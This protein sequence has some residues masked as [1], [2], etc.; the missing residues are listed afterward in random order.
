MAIT[1]NGVNMSREA[2][3]QNVA[4]MVRALSMPN[5]HAEL[6][7]DISPQ[8]KLSSVKMFVDGNLEKR[9]DKVRKQLEF[10]AEA[11]DEDFGALII[12]YINDLPLEAYDTG[13]SDGERMLVWLG[14]KKQLT[15]EQD[16]YVVCQ[17][18]RHTIEDIARVNRIRHTRFTELH[19][20]AEKLSDELYTNDQLQIYLNP[21]RYWTRF[22][23]TAL[24]DEQATTPADVMFF[25]AGKET[26]T[27]ILDLE[28]QALINELADYQPCTLGQWSALSQLADHQQ[29]LELCVDLSQMG[30][31]AFG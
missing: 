29:L 27:A 22:N 26:A 8:S 31:V 10:V 15:P 2:Y 12:E 17:Q 23:T 19:S 7:G 21:I 13:A 9:F 28:G 1:E 4:R 18:A 3:I 20:I 30:L 14:E 25:A 5:Q 16:D 6:S 24:I 11:F